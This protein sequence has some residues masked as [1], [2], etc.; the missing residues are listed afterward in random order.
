MKLL[1]WMRNK[2]TLSKEKRILELREAVFSIEKENTILKEKI[3]LLEKLSKTNNI[4]KLV[5]NV[6]KLSKEKID[7]ENKIKYKESIINNLKVQIEKLKEENM[8]L[9]AKLG[10]IQDNN[11]EKIFINFYDKDI[12]EVILDNLNKAKA[13]VIVAMAWF[14]SD[15]LKRAISKLKLEGKKIKIIL[16]DDDKNDFIINQFKNEGIDI[17]V[18]KVNNGKWSRMHNKYCIIDD[19][20]VVDGSYNWTGNAKRNEEHIIVI[21]SSE[22]TNKYKENFYRIYNTKEYFIT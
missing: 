6:E 15:D 21:K 8:N 18:A 2:L 11:K 10:F 1:N 19:Y 5:N 7:L 14:T 20:L 9:I 4:E 12:E 3:I 13:E 17:K 16:S 22:V